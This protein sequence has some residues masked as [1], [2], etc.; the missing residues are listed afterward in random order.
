MKV[1]YEN[2][3]KILSMNFDAIDNISKLQEYKVNLIDSYRYINNFKELG[4]TTESINRKFIIQIPEISLD[5]FVPRDKFMT[6]NI[7]Y[8]IEK[9]NERI[10]ELY[11]KYIRKTSPNFESGM[12]KGIYYSVMNDCDENRGGYY[13][14]FFKV[15]NEN[16]QDIDFD[17]RL[18]YMVIHIDN[19][20]EMKHSKIIV[21]QYINQ[22]LTELKKENEEEEL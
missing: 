12:Y 8:A 18:D 3:K 15:I 5:S 17:N 16:T 2:C 11:I 21:E 20:Y 14:E 1:N 22:L 9:I 6:D 7:N 4:L 10:K 13:V 19:E